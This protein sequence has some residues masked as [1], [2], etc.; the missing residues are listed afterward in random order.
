MKLGFYPRLAI[1]G[2]R[3]NKRLYIPYILTC[4]GMIMMYY[5]IIYLQMSDTLD[6]MRGIDV[7]REILLMGSWVI[8]F[9]ACIFL[10]YTNSFLMRRRKKEFGL[11]NILGM[12]KANI[13]IV[14]FWECVIIGALTLALG[15][16]FGIAFSKF[17]ELC[18][19]KIMRDTANYTLTVSISG[20]LMTCIVFGVIF[21][22]LFLNSVRQVRFS[23]AIAMLR[24]ENVGEKP[25][26][27]N[28]LFGAAGVIILDAAY[29]IAVTIKNPIAAITLF[30]V[31]VIMVIAATYLIMIAGSVVF[32]RL[33]QKNKSYYYKPNHFVSVSSMVYRMKRN[34]AGLASI[35]I[36]ATMVLVMLS[37]TT[38]LYFGGEDMV[39]SSC[40]REICVEFGFEKAA[41]MTDD[42]VRSIED[43]VVS[44]AGQNG[45]AVQNVMSYRTVAVAGLVEGSTVE[46]DTRR[47][48]N[49]NFSTMNNVYQFYFL[50]L[51]DY[52]A[53][54]GRNE[55]LSDGQA[56]I[57]SGI[58]LHT[59]R[60]N[61]TGGENFEIVKSVDKFLPDGSSMISVPVVYLI[62]P[63][64]SAA[65]HGL[66]D[67]TDYSGN[68]IINAR[69]NYDFDTG[70]EGE[71]EEELYDRLRDTLRNVEDENAPYLFCTFEL[72]S[73][74]RDDFME[75][76]GGFFYLGILLSIVFMLATVLII[77][78]K[79]ISEGY[80]D[81]GR[82]EIMQKVGM[83]RRE[84]KRSINSQLLTVFL[85]PL[86]FAGMHMCFAFPIIR[87]LLLLFQ[88]DNAGLFMGTTAIS[89]I[90]FTVFYMIVYKI[91]SNT[92]Y[93]LV[94][95]GN[96][97]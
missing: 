20:I 25:P 1:D 63:D 10:F 55:K 93:K 92:Y 85:L 6:G 45:A 26:K 47:V 84:I 29:Y 12:G 35:C 57:Y 94:S 58:D 53:I 50:S 74:T 76:S 97:E 22:L 48:D 5:I 65:V 69:L 56:L 41:M 77:Y 89:F 95:D 60:L 54:T 2:I 18:L 13:A 86:I 11:Y 17:A 73:H 62:V 40:P 49:F 9:F 72:R 51:D 78:Y 24:S 4:I 61:F 75:L 43:R 21:I 71:R 37:S 87:K 82:F 59:D 67:M 30:F 8:A 15:L 46:T 38:A 33:L 96:R 7:T 44:I 42:G 23:S 28:I 32:C 36:L 31:A 91:T 81:Q 83:T 64:L 79:Q 70:L 34:G 80:E 88:L 3:K 68:S 66:D 27:G 90:I 52:N 19:V 14:L 16:I 39:N